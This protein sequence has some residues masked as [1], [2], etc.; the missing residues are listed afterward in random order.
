MPRF[1]D[2]RRAIYLDCLRSGGWRSEA[3]AAAGVAYSTVWRHAKE[4]EA[5]RQET[6]EAELDANTAV[7]GALYRRAVEG[8]VAACLAWLYSRSPDR[9]SDRRGVATQVLIATDPL[10][11][12][13]VEQRR[14]LLEAIRHTRSDDG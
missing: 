4:D 14:L 3:A 1:T 8:H 6:E 2:Q 13:P 5:F 7:E 10:E 9:W 12:L 11:P